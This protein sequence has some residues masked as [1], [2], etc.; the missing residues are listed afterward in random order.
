MSPS[1]NP[2]EPD[3]P[4]RPSV[5]GSPSELGQALVLR[6]FEMWNT[7]Q[8]SAADELLAPTYIEHSHPDFVGP[9]AARSLVPRVHALFPGVVVRAEIVA[10]DRDFVA[11]RTVI[12]PG[13]AD[14]HPDGPRRGM[15]LFRVADGKL[16]EQWSWY[17]PVR[18]DRAA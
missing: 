10:S 3:T 14:G 6:Y 17:A 16:A 1:P 15:A 9:A 7:G 11:V 12:E 2:S 13:D 5:A 18:R 4:T 8:G